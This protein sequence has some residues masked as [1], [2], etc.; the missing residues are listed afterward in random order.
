M[1]LPNQNQVAA[2]GR[3]VLTAVGA[4]TAFASAMAL[5]TPGEAANVVSGFQHLSN[6]ASEFMLGIGTLIPVGS[7]LWA[8]WTASRKS[9]VQSAASIPGTTVVTTAAL[10]AATPNQANIVSNTQNVVVAKAT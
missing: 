3:H 1:N 2:V 4:I 5:L 8:A 6:A 10:A 9:V 7:A